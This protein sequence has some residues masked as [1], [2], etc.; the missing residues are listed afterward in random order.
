[1]NDADRPTT[2]AL[3]SATPTVH[4]EPGISSPVDI[5]GMEPGTDVDNLKSRNEKAVKTTQDDRDSSRSTDDGVLVVN[6]EGPDDPQNPQ[7][8]VMH[9]YP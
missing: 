9:L 3:P 2:S 4:D 5:S 7:K 1:M 6:W 8:Y